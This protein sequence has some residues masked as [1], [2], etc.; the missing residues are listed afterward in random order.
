MIAPITYILSS[1]R[2]PRHSREVMALYALAETLQKEQA[3]AL[4]ECLDDSTGVLYDEE[5]IQS[6]REILHRRHCSE[7][8]YPRYRPIERVIAEAYDSS[9][10]I[11][12]LNELQHRFGSQTFEEQRAILRLFLAQDEPANSYRAWAYDY[13]L[14]C[15]DE[16]FIPDIERCWLAYQ[17]CAQLV[18]K[19]LPE[20]FVLQYAETLGEG[21]RYKELCLRLCNHPAFQIER[22]RL[23]D[24][25]DY[26]EILQRK[27][28]PVDGEKLLQ[29]FLYSLCEE[30]AD[31][32]QCISAMV[33]TA[34]NIVG[35]QGY[36]ASLK[37]LPS[38]RDFIQGLSRLGLQEQ[39]L[40]FLFWDQALRN[41]HFALLNAEYDDTGEA[42]PP[43]AYYR[44]F[45]QVALAR[46]SGQ[47]V[48]IK[49]GKAS[50]IPRIWDL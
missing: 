38:V 12:L 41:E 18:I 30:L 50:W 28:E 9:H 3:E 44:L 42:R 48:S 35:E 17:D 19:R 46:L 49:F 14:L 33:D 5:I 2:S 29:K 11:V 21:N 10:N 27:G 43:R 22:E 40:R 36:Y 16:A 1:L 47:S 23:Q 15:W 45:C 13:L 25:W 20:S 8:I 4:Y 32:E 26:L 37:L 39:L 24:E 31:T 34:N 7:R 6:L